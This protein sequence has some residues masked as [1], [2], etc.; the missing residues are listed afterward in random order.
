MGGDFPSEII[1]VPII[2]LALP[3]LI[4]HYVTKW[5]SAATITTD[6]EALLDDLYQLARRLDERMDTVER[7]VAADHPDFENTR[8]L[9]NRETDNQPLRELERMMTEKKGEYR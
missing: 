4:M 3:W 6:D 7:L 9:P 8:L 1:I 2:V 5:K